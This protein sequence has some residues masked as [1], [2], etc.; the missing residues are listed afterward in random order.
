MPQGWQ[1]TNSMSFESNGAGVETI[2]LQGPNGTVTITATEGPDAGKAADA[3]SG[4]GV[5]RRLADDLT[6]IVEGSAGVSKSD[7]K[8]IADAIRRK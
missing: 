4:S 5:V 6:V 8:K 7:L 2:Q 1:Q 3:Y